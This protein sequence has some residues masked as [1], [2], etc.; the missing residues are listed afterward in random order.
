MK[1]SKSLFV[2]IA[3]AVLAFSVSVQADISRKKA[4]KIGKEN[5]QKLIGESYHYKVEYDDIIA[6]PVHSKTIR[7][8]D[9]YLLY[10]L[11]DNHF[12]VEMEVDKKTG[13]PTILAIG[14][15]SP[16]YH[17]PLDG[18]FSD[19]Y[20]NADSIMNIGFRRFRLKQD[21][22][23]LVYFG[24]IPRLGKRGVIWELFSGEGRKYISTTGATVKID[25][26]IRDV[27]TNQRREGNFAADSI[28]LED[29]AAEIARL[30]SLTETERNRIILTPERL[31]SLTGAYKQEMETI[32][33]K[34]PKL[35]GKVKIKEN[36]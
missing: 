22:V 19:K 24:V 36:K 34:F 28:R 18:T 29:L 30:N 16:P 20:F 5:F 9:F 21:S 31:D 3:F 7:K 4:M 1:T 6:L 32:Y 15:M 12:Q 2:L 17:E 23:R 10:F 14:L 25:E 13:N 27:N 33:A 11:K 35:R 26:L 8:N